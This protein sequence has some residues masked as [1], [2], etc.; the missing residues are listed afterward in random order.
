MLLILYKPKDNIVNHRD[1][2][3][4]S[5]EAEDYLQDFPGSVC[6]SCSNTNNLHHNFTTKCFNRMF[7]NYRIRDWLVPK[8]NNNFIIL[9]HETIAIQTKT[10]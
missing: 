7:G 5:N 2:L 6:V 10:R 3:V 4:D 1:L 9:K 8:K